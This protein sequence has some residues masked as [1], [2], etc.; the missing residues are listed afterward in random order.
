MKTAAIYARVSSDQ[1]KEDKTIASQTAALVTFA[2]ERAYSVP[3]EWIFEDEG[4]SGAT[5]VR[6][7]L[8]RVRDLVAEGQIQAV[9]VLSPD[10]LSRKYAYQVLLMEE[11][12]RQG[13]E[14]I[15]I[16]APQSQT[17]EDQLLVQFQGMIAE[18]ERAQILERSRRGK[19]H[20]A[21]QGEASVL[22][23]APYGY[24][25]VRK[26]Q[27]RCAYYEIDEAQAEIVRQVFCLYTTDASSIGAI[28]RHLNELGVPTSKKQSCWERSTIWGMLRNPAYKG[29]ACFGKTQA[30]VR[31]QHTNRIK[32]MGGRTPCGTHTTQRA[33]KEQ[34]IQIPVPALVDEQTFE[35][36][37]ERLQDNQKFSLRRTVEPSILQGLVHCAQCGYALYR[38][39]TRSSARKIYYY[40]CLGSDAWRYQGRAR[41]DA[42][43][44]RLDLLEQTVWDE[45]AHLLEDPALIQAELTRRVEA[46]R[47]SNP[48]KHHQDRLEH[49]LKQAQRG[50]ERLL[51]AYQ[52][53]LLSLDELRRRMPEIRQ[54]E[55]RLKAELE[56]QVAQLADQATYLRLA[57]TLREFLDR[58]H[59]QAQ[60][61]GVME[62]QRILRLL[63]KEVIVGQDS[64]T[65]R[66]SIPNVSRPS[67]GSTGPADPSPQLPE[68]AESGKSSLLRMWREWSTLW[69]AHLARLYL[70]T[71][72]HSG[73]QVAPD[74]SQQSLV[75]NGFPQQ[76]HQHVMVDGVKEL[77]QIDVHCDASAVLHSRLHLPDRLVCIA[78]WRVA[79]TRFRERRVISA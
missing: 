33:P 61:L 37:Q 76:V 20:R 47:A 25:Y 22:C 36:A 50:L 53:D 69:G 65:I 12:L 18:Y 46:A 54:R 49:D 13:V 56:A 78:A 68:K 23:G 38:T 2:S 48:A 34:W 72:Q 79:E 15:F 16:K 40:R 57:H 1:Q 24:R 32:R 6:P 42:K 19:R 77:G 55:T 51:T 26:S 66:H 35:L 28:T 60:N 59:R 31:Q 39:S 30:A 27:E 4:V 70:L 75:G 52:E 8:E 9:L 62:Q 29:M 44:I 11:W 64:I 73:A 43:P 41:C 3:A 10:R 58:L 45:V 14:T 21:K 17:P 63:V 7:G 67:G 74:Q 71:D 5:L